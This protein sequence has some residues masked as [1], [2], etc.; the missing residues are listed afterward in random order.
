MSSREL[1]R[2]TADE[3]VKLSEKLQKVRESWV[4][5]FH[6]SQLLYRLVTAGRTWLPFQP[7]DKSE[8]GRKTLLFNVPQHIR[9]SGL[10]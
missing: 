5:N 8:E 9:C 3:K 4:P 7:I 6:L 1:G 2:Q 10:P